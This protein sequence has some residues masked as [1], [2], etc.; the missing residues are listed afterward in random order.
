VNASTTALIVE[1]SDVTIS[2]MTLRG[3]GYASDASHMA[4]ELLGSG[5]DGYLDTITV[6]G[7][8][9]TNWDGDGIYAR[10]LDGFIFSANTISNIWYAGIEAYSVQHGQI[11][12]NVISNVIGTGN[13]YGIAL[14]RGYGGGLSQNPRSSDVSVSGN[15][16]E[17]IPNW[18]GLDTHAGQ[19]ITF[20]NNTIRR[21]LSPIMVGG[22]KDSEDGAFVF[23]PLQ[24]TVSGNQIASGVTNGTMA[25]EAIFFGGAAGSLGS[26]TQLA[27]GSISDNTIT[28][29]GLQSNGEYSAIKVANTSG[30]T[31]TANA[32]LDASPTGIQVYDDNYNFTVSANTITD[33]WSQSLGYAIGVYVHDDYNTGLISG[34]QFVHAGKVAAYVLTRKISIEP[35]PHNHVTVR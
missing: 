30:L 34:N 26:P 14:T 27:T 22:S 4:I 21:V 35:F 18:E 28:G 15:V 16:I 11:T 24:V 12:G 10:F 29:Y 17:D 20:T 9:L 1:S 5:V 31:V 23:A 19:R 8:T 6:S 32:I 3:P 13:A 25:G 2:G 33:A 7:N